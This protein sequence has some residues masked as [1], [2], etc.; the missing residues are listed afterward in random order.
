MNRK[1]AVSLLLLLVLVAFAP[2]PARAD[3]SSAAAAAPNNAQPIDV[4]LAT[5]QHVLIVRLYVKKGNADFVKDW[6]TFLERR[7]QVADADGDGTLNAEELKTI[8]PLITPLKPNRNQNQDFFVDDDENPSTSQTLLSDPPTENASDRRLAAGANCQQ[9]VEFLRA[10]M[11]TPVRVEG[12]VQ[13][14]AGSAPLFARLDDD[15]DG[16]LSTDECARAYDVLE[17]LDY[18]NTEVFSR[19]QLMGT[20][21]AGRRVVAG[22]VRGAQGQNQPKTRLALKLL[23]QAGTGTAVAGAERIRAH[24][25][26]MVKDR[27][28]D[29]SVPN[30]P[31]AALLYDEATFSPFDADGDGAL[32]SD[33]LAQLIRRPH[34]HLE[35]T[36]YI[37]RQLPL[38]TT[39][40]HFDP[41]AAR[42]EET[43]G[44]STL[45]IGDERIE[46][47]PAQFQGFSAQNQIQNIESRFKQADEDNNEYLDN[48]EAQRYGMGGL[49]ALDADGDGK[50]YMREITIYINAEAEMAAHRLVIAI[51]DYGHGMFEAID[52]D[53]D[54][55]LSR[56]ELRQLPKR[57]GQWDRDGDGKL[58]IEEIPHL[59]TLQVAQEQVR[60][61]RNNGVFGF[62]RAGGRGRGQGDR[63]AR[64][65]PNWFRQMDRNGDG[66][67]SVQEFLGTPA[68][69]RK[70]DADGDQLI[71]AEEATATITPAAEP[72]TASSTAT[73]SAAA[74]VPDS[75]PPTGDAADDAPAE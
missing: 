55:L 72:T 5:D 46:L 70:F 30:V 22:G 58:S 47:T 43:S 4:A 34:P 2:I 11:N 59:Y 73:A 26:S 57:I 7:F 20:T 71:D 75:P 56:R 28:D 66:D 10:G 35:L 29:E 13:T 44:Q 39:A 25:A 27:R 65:A 50:L 17:S 14:S 53:H 21:G 54:E 12:R 6:Q 38:S 24:F 63:M 3:D 15:H 74:T 60:L 61:P 18:Y 19:N 40:T 41:A 45:T 8:G 49:M 68:Q 33:E 37:D 23:T 48:R 1:T 32:D 42:L 52:T 67:L 51:V 69:F 64:S 16:K 36:T 62:N 9:F 31:R